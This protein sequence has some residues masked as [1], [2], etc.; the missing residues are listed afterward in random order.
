MSLA[1][2]QN[3]SFEN[4]WESRACAR[5]LSD[6]TLCLS[7]RLLH[8]FTLRLLSSEGRPFCKS[9]YFARVHSTGRSSRGPTL[10]RSTAWE[11]HRARITSS[12]WENLLY[13]R[14]LHINSL[15]LSANGSKESSKLPLDFLKLSYNKTYW[16]LKQ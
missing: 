4:R 6:F 3:D 8:G 5:R 7:L 15:I 9:V 2:F 12:S 11:R 13:S 10:V 14:D 1:L 16:F